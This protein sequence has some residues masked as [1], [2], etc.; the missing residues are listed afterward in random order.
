MSRNRPRSPRTSDHILIRLTEGIDRIATALAE[1][2]REPETA[3]VVPELTVCRYL[4]LKHLGMYIE[5]V[6]RPV[7]RAQ[8]EEPSIMVT[9]GVLVGIRPGGP[10]RGSQPAE[11]GLVISQGGQQGVTSLRVDAPVKVF[12]RSGR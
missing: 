8:H 5:V 6:P 2:R 10:G 7:E 12:P 11:R 9:A 4:S 3:L 1:A